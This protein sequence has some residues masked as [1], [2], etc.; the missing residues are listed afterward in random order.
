[1]NKLH[2]PYNFCESHPVVLHAMSRNWVSLTQ[3]FI[4]ILI[5]LELQ[6]SAKNL[7]VIIRSNVH[8]K[9]TKTQIF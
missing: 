1:M 7:E 5:I 2:R 3:L 4:I 6:I 9:D 8:K